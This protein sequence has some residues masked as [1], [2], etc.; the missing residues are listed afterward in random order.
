MSIRS[1]VGV[2]VVDIGTTDTVILTVPEVRQSVSAMSLHNTTSGT[3]IPVEIYISPDATTAG[4]TRVAYYNI[5]GND[6]YDVSEL[7]GQGF[8]STEY[9]VAIADVVGIN[10]K[11]TVTVFSGDS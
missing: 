4:G 5:P 10:V 3:S 1:K 8:K 9:V 7:I 2:D 11:S 6:S